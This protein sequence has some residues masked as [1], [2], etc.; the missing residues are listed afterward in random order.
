MPLEMRRRINDP[1]PNLYNP[2]DLY[3]PF[4]DPPPQDSN[5]INVLSIVEGGTEFEP[6]LYS[7]RSTVEDVARGGGDLG[8]GRGPL[9][10]YDIDNA[11]ASSMPILMPDRF[12]PGRGIFLNTVPGADDLCDGSYTSFCNRGASNDCLLGGM[13]DYRGGLHFDCLSGWLIFNVPRIMHGIIMIKLETY[14]EA[15]PLTQGW[16]SINNNTDVSSSSTATAT[17]EGGK[18]GGTEENHNPDADSSRHHHQE[19]RQPP[20]QRSL[21]SDTKKQA[22]K[23]NKKK[24][25]PESDRWCDEFAFEYALNG[26]V[27]K[28]NK[29]D[30]FDLHLQTIQRTVSIVTLLDDEKVDDSLTS[31][32][33]FQVA[34]RMT[35]CGRNNNDNNQGFQLTHVYWA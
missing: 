2:P 34:I 12:E 16:T 5:A 3:N 15:S 14:H 24:G 31:L 26:Q 6:L 35:G 30:F 25:P 19:E 22:K 23:K 28:W 4:L 10:Y 9:E 1:E 7:S 13:N 20:Q 18:L 27:T 11:I 33:N 29:F 32:S 21:Q 17:S 8:D